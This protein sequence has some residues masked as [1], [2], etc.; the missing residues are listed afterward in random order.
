M[1]AIRHIASAASFAAF[2]ALAPLAQ[3]GI[4]TADAATACKTEAQARYSAGERLARVKFK[5]MYGGAALRKVRVQVLPPEGKAFLAVCEV[6]GQGGE[7]VSLQ[8][9]AKPEASVAVAGG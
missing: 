2:A 6:S 9:V 4:S 7:R 5:G 8:P 1:N 3:A